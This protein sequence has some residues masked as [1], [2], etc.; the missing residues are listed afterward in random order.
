MILTFHIYQ[1]NYFTN[2]ICK[3]TSRTND[4][5]IGKAIMF[6]SMIT[7]NYHKESIHKYY[8]T[9]RTKII[10]TMLKF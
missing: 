2:N 6:I 1:D 10:H 8:H 9:P 3:Y 7:V 4:Y 5:H